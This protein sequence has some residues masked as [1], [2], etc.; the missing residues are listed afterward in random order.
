MNATMELPVDVVAEH[1]R[2]QALLDSDPRVL[3][4]EG[5]ELDEWDHLR[6]ASVKDVEWD[7]E[8]GDLH[9]WLEGKTTL[10]RR[11]ARATHWQPAE[12]VN[13]PAT[14]HISIVWD[15]NPE[16]NP[17]VDIEVVPE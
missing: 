9:V 7:D 8:H 16:S 2:Q 17:S 10:S 15:F 14:V 1:A 6:E 5:V 13:D 11:V 12:Y 4:P 3:S